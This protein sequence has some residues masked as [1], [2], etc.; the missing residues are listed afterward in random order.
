MNS[1][2][3]LA[4]L[5]FHKLLLIYLNIYQI[6]SKSICSKTSKARHLSML[7]QISERTDLLKRFHFRSLSKSGHLF[8]CGN[9]CGR[10]DTPL[11][12]LHCICNMVIIRSFIKLI[13]IFILSLLM[14]IF[15]SLFATILLLKY[16]SKIF[17]EVSLLQ[18]VSFLF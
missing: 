12:W 18:S 4:L 3:F 16:L 2:L 6:I 13:Y 11:K 15:E 7:G 1:A 10:T 14:L 9:T 17:H 8:M 5:Y